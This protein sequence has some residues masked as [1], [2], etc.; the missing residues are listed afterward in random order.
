MTGRNAVLVV[1][2]DPIVNLYTCHIFEDAGLDVTSFNNADDA[3][4]Y[5][6]EH[7]G[8]VAAVFTDVHMPGFS[9]GFHLAEL[10]K[11][12]WPKI[13]VIVTSGQ[14]CAPGAFRR[15]IHFF[16][17]PWRAAEVIR[18]VTAS[19]SADRIAAIG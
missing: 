6:W 13:E 18:L 3:L 5:L 12:H 14:D 1:E 10:I 7:A 4:V 16:C 2:D 15:D 8:N 19:T 9:D 17:K 11:R